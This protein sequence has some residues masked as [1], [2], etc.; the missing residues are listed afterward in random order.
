MTDVGTAARM[1]RRWLLAVVAAVLGLAF[2][3]LSAGAGPAAYG[4]SV[5]VP[6]ELTVTIVDPRPSATPSAGSPKQLVRVR[7]GDH[8]VD[9]DA[10][11]ARGL[12]SGPVE[13]TVTAPPGA[14]VDARSIGDLL[15]TG[16]ARVEGVRSTAAA[17]PTLGLHHVLVVPV[18]WRSQPTV[19]SDELRDVVRET[20]NYYQTATQGKIRFTADSVRPWTKISLTTAQQEACDN[21]AIELAVR[22]LAGSYTTDATHH[23][24]AYMEQLPSCWWAGLANLGTGESQSFVWIND[25]PV[26]SIWGHEF[27]H[28][29]ELMHSGSLYCWDDAQHTE[30]VPLS[31]DCDQETYSDPWDLMGNQPYGGGMM[32]AEN[33]RRLGVLPASSSTVVSFATELTLAPLT[34]TSGVRGAQFSDGDASYFLEY[35]TPAGLDDWIDD[36][37]YVDPGGVRRTDPGGGLVMRRNVAGFGQWG[38]QDVV[39]FHPDGDL[40]TLGRHPGME[41]GESYTLPGGRVRVTVLSVS[42]AGARVAISFPNSSGVY[43]WSGADRYAAAAAITRASFGSDVDRLYVASGEVFTDALSAAAVAGREGAPLL[44]VKRDQIPDA[45]FDEIWRLNPSRII[46][47]GGTATISSRVEAGL[48]L[49]PVDR[50]AGADRYETS[51]LISARNYSP[52][53]AVA[54]VASGQ[55][56]PDALAG[57]PVAGKTGGP[58]LLVPSTAVPD[59]VA[60]ELRRLRPGRIVVLGG[61]ATIDDGVLATLGTFTSGA[62]ERW[63]GADRYAVS[64]SISERSFPSGAET[65]FVAS[66]LVFPDSLAGAPVAGKTPAPLLLLRTASIPDPVAAELTR[67]RPKQIVILGGPASVTNTAAAALQAYVRH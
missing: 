38:E 66:G 5:R 27:G 41:A 60:S 34:A 65:V 67:L 10:D 63:A 32:S 35:R 39:D 47:L 58:V 43:R 49:V 52:G 17:R 15:R 40:S 12:S 23:I 14:R 24:V 44:L 59:S 46:L 26:A 20:D 21:D 8:T 33:L 11:L 3:G 62:V 28:N 50:I 48:S 16:S 13:V 42:A 29:L 7:V 18:Y 25:Y 9:L 2:G 55:N 53:V 4:Q 22:R 19:T 31:G 51:A 37:T 56:F 30:A 1:W 57:A 64:A 54:Y 61:P 36:A 6:G 45:T